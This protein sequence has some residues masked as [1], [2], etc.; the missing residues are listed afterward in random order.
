MAWSVSSAQFDGRAVRL[1]LRDTDADLTAA[2]ALAQREKECCPFF[3]VA[4]DIAAD[5]RTRVQ[6]L[7]PK[8]KSSVL[9]SSHLFEKSSVGLCESW[10]N[11]GYVRIGK[12]HSHSIVPG[13]LEVMS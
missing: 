7:F 13:G 1:V 10:R 5:R 8:P 3:D 9:M 2:V 11:F 6:H 12:N 4:L